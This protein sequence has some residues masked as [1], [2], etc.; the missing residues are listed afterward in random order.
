MNQTTFDHFRQYY[1]NEDIRGFDKVFYSVGDNDSC[2]FIVV[3]GHMDDFRVF[4]FGSY[5]EESLE[6]RIFA[7]I[8]QQ[9]HRDVPDRDVI[10]EVRPELLQRERRQIGLGETGWSLVVC[11]YLLFVECIGAGLCVL[12]GVPISRV[13]WVTAACIVVN[14][15]LFITFKRRRVRRPNEWEEWQ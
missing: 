14:I 13:M 7:L 5:N 4:S 11:V 15:L 3:R 12:I 8:A 10:D 1:P 2:A 6:R 9:P